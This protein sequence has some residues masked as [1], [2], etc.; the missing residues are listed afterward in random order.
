MRPHS[1]VQALKTG[2]Q[3][4]DIRSRGRQW[5]SAQS[6]R[7]GA[8]LAEKKLEMAAYLFELVYDL[9]IA[10][11]DN[12]SGNPGFEALIGYYGEDK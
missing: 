8:T 9:M 7:R 5:V 11:R 4:C 2:A 3:D 12:V 6:I 10:D 1:G